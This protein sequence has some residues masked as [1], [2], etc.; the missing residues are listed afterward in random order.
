MTM[1][2]LLFLWPMLAVLSPNRLTPGGR[3]L[4]WFVT[5]ILFVV[6]MGFRHEVGGD[7][8]NYLPI[9]QTASNLTLSETASLSDPGYYVLSWLIEQQGGK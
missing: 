6:V 2:W 7:W 9:F 1:Y 4:V 8:F 3:R 5:A